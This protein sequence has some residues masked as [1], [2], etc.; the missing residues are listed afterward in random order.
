MPS[1]AHRYL[2]QALVL[3]GSTGEGHPMRERYWN[4]VFQ[5]MTMMS[6]S[7]DDNDS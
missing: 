2:I 1:E 3:A 7:G 6:D 4:Q 5:M